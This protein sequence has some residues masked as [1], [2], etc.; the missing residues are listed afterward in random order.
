MN[1]EIFKI[2]KNDVRANAL[3]EM[4]KERFEDINKESKT[5][6]IV[7]EYYEVI[8]ELISALMYLNGFKT[9]SHKMLVIYL[10]RNYKEFNKSE[11]ILINEL[12]KLRNNILYYGQKVEK[13]FLLNNK[14]ELNLI[15]K[16]L[17]FLL[18]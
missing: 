8:K 2:T 18:K 15:I 6:R 5:Y 11:I 1:D 10:E 14:K 17:F 3:V 16:K 4:A 13:E 7:E 12:R 9:L